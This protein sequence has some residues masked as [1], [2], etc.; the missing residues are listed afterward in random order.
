MASQITIRREGR[1]LDGVLFAEYGVDGRKVLAE[2][3]AANPGLAALGP[4]LPLGTVV[5]I[6]DLPAQDK[7]AATE[8]V[9]LFS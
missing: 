7:A 9:T 3:L 5:T 2:T 8:I 1:T 6:P 4:I